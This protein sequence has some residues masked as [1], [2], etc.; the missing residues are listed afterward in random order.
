MA[1]RG[2]ASGQNRIP[3]FAGNRRVRQIM[4]RQ[5]LLIF[6]VAA[7]LVAATAGAISYRKTHQRLGVPGVTVV[8]IPIHDPEGNVAGTNSVALP[9][10]VLNFTSQVRP[11]EKLVLD[12]LPKDT[13]YGQ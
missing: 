11:V 2:Q 3:R 1:G 6:L 4:K 10:K 9:E 8:P 12:W 13:I 7:S 5:S